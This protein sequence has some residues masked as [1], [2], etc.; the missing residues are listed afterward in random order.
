MRHATFA[1]LFATCLTSAGCATSPWHENLMTP[2]EMA[3]AD[4][5][6]LAAEQKRVEE[7]AKHL[8]ET[9]SSG[10]SGVVFLALLDAYAQSKGAANTGGAG[11]TQAA[12]QSETNA[13][14]ARILQ[15]KVALIERFRARRGCA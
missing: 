3:L 10:K 1:L 4:C 8:N 5:P 2:H 14:Q 12:E 15:Q 9:A 13:A 7:N 6:S 11:A